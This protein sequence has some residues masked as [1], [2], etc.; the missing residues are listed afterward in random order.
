MEYAANRP[1]LQ[2]FFRSR[3]ADVLDTTNQ[4]SSHFFVH[5]AIPSLSVRSLGF[6]LFGLVPFSLVVLL[7]VAFDHR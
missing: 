1:I 2:S 6:P 5:D 4:E 7:E 3:V